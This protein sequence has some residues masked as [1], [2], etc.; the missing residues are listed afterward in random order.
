MVS[1]LI[2]VISCPEVLPEWAVQSAHPHITMIDV[3]SRPTGATLPIAEIVSALSFFD[4]CSFGAI[5][6]D[7]VIARA[8][9][10]M[11]KGFQDGWL[12][13][14]RSIGRRALYEAGLSKSLSKTDAER[15]V[16][17]YPAHHTVLRYSAS[18]PPRQLHS[19]CS[20]L[21]KKYDFS[22]HVSKVCL[23]SGDYQQ[24]GLLTV[25]KE[26]QNKRI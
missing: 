20:N 15:Y 26:W 2:P 21:A 1:L 5:D 4:N 13:E 8:D 17:E 22:F 11:A 10:V 14:L 9:S 19:V 7:G 12:T 6:F 25:H 23:V 24:M 16:L 18:P 3:L